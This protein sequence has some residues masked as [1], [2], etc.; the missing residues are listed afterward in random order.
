[1]FTSLSGE[2]MLRSQLIS[3]CCYV[4][5]SVFEVYA[6]LGKKSASELR[7]AAVTHAHKLAEV[8]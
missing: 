7:E 2:R 1:M 5:V 8:F 4:I 3:E 6:Y